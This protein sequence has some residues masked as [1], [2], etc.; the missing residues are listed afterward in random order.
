M[1]AV[2]LIVNAFLHLRQ[3]PALLYSENK[4]EKSKKMEAVMKMQSTFDKIRLKGRRVPWRRVFLAIACVLL[5]AGLITAGIIYII[6]LQEGVGEFFPGLDI[7]T[8]K[9]IAETPQSSTMPPEAVIGIPVEVPVDAS[10]PK[11]GGKHPHGGK[12][13][14]KHPRDKSGKDKEKHREKGEK[15]KDKHP[16]DK[17]EKDKHREKGEKGK[18]KHREKNKG[19][20]DHHAHAEDKDE[21]ADSNESPPNTQTR[22]RLR[23][24]DP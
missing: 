18:D 9:I 12:D 8:S 15:G 14:D 21:H 24:L 3:I 16:R 2:P 20:G 11:K 4:Y 7:G 22:R 17:S 10:V 23:R 1:F 6:S 5:C 13:K 19:V